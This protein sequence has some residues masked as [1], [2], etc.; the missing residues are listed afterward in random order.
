MPSVPPEFPNVL[1]W[2][3]ESRAEVMNTI[4]LDV[5]E[6]VFKATHS[7]SFIQ[8]QG[9]RRGSFVPVHEHDFLDDF[10]RDEHVHVFDIA[11]GDS[12]TGKSHLIRWMYHEI[13]RR[14]TRNGDRYWVV[15]VPRSSANLADVV[16]RIL[17]GFEGETTTRL[18][19]ELNRHR[20]LPFGEA[21]NRVIDELAYAL[22]ADVI[23]PEKPKRDRSTVEIA[24]LQDLPAL[25]RAQSL[26]KVLIDPPKGIVSRVAR[27][28]LGQREEVSEEKDLKWTADDLVFGVLE[29]ERAGQ[30]AQ[31]L[32]L[33]LLEDDKARGVAAEF[34]NQAQRHALKSLL[35]FRSG[36]MKT[37]VAEIRR[38]LLQKHKELVV[39]IEDLS[40]T[41]GLDAELVEALQVRTRDTGE[42]LC[43]LR[44]IV[45]VTN[46]DY[47]RMRENIAEGRTLRTLFFN[48]TLGGGE[49]DSTVDRKAVLAFASRYLNAARYSIEEL[50][51]WYRNAASNEALPSVCDECPNRRACHDAF[52]CFDGRG[53]YPLSPDTIWRL[54]D[55]VASA[56]T[57]SDRAF[58]PRLLV[59]R[60]LSGV[61]E[62]AEQSLG[63]KAYP[64]SSLTTAFGLDLVRAD[65]QIALR[66]HIG[67]NA[68]RLRRALDLYSPDPSSLKPVLPAGVSRA[69]DLPEL[70]TS[71]LEVNEG[72]TATTSDA[73]KP[74]EQRSVL[75][76]YD[77]WLRG[78]PVADRDANVWRTAV[79]SAIR[80]WIDWDALGL[81]SVK[82]R[83]KA[84]SI[85]F[86]GQF[87]R[88]K[89]DISLEIAREPENAIAVR[90]LV[91]RFQGTAD[92]VEK[93]IRL[94]RRQIASWSEAVIND[95][96]RF[97]LEPGDPTPTAVA[98]EFLVL[99]ALLRGSITTRST[100]IEIVREALREW[101][102]EIPSSR[103]PEWTS[104]W[105]AF[106]KYSAP[107]R[108]LLINEIALT[109]GSISG[110]VIDISRVGDSMRYVRANGKPH[111]LPAE[112]E[113]WLHH[114]PVTTLARE[115]MRHLD[116]AISRERLD[117][118]QWLQQLK[119][120][121]GDT[122]L[123]ETITTIK[124]AFNAADSV[125]RA[126]TAGVQDF[127]A[128]LTSI[129]ARPLGGCVG[130]VQRALD[131][132]DTASQIT[133][134][135]RVDRALMADVQRVL[136]NASGVLEATTQAV[137]DAVR[138]SA[139]EDLAA[140][141]NEVR[142]LTKR[143]AADLATLSGGTK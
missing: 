141:E 76:Q 31:E 33:M 58:N 85:R 121:I 69:F 120:W 47:V 39:L 55:R 73:P 4:A 127:P 102:A 53:L 75:D 91:G 79:Y 71:A 3:P 60:V 92:D 80:A 7:P 17:I 67:A 23:D 81:A 65:V 123:T 64:R 62:E 59:G 124:K 42:E 28:V 88:Q 13:V 8:Q 45:G 129:A 103:T 63:A 32:A 110:S 128:Q 16:R 51:A 25:L 113:A 98:A 19:E 6:A 133:H 29:S 74:V 142:D 49:R 90:G 46:E 132:S 54:Y 84:V 116:L 22:E 137:E 112:S 109:K 48:M 97:A 50:G 87:T 101:P 94:S 100:D 93:Q 35:R 68:E 2:Q 139:T 130:D 34:L 126:R 24:V 43:R 111:E 57:E 95:L 10:L 27:H 140:I 37:A 44:S 89:T 36:D 106:K 131:S 61:L 115:T 14:N 26:R 56:R 104:L 9:A 114:K 136:K 20:A 83:F 21:K 119:Q 78:D 143:V 11:V 117:L 134:I 118:E 107:V 108:E 52:G 135:A 70:A 1:C 122:E 82:S 40:V 86:V 66:D 41:E 77:R 30:S 96:R 18:L 99:G 38:D 15:L 125:G 12:G 72:P 105:N 138:Q 5:P